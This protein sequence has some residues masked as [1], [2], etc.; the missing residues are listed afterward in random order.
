MKIRTSIFLL[1]LS[2]SLGLFFTQTIFGEGGSKNTAKTTKAEPQDTT[3]K[4]IVAI[5]NGQKVTRQELY[6]LLVDTY[7]DDAL[8]V[9]I[10][11]TLIY[12]A[13]A[14]EGISA[15]SSELNQKLKILIN[16]EIDGL[17]RTYRIKDKAD[18][19]KEL[20]KIDSS[21]AQLEEKLSKK[22]RKQAE[23]EVLAEKVMTKTVTVTEEELKK[24]YDLEY[25]EKIEA[26]QIVYNIRSD[27]E[28]ALKKIKSG[29]D[30]ATMAKNDSIDR[31]SAAKGG[32]MQPFSPKDGI[33]TQVAN[34]KVGEISDIIKTDYGYHIIQ[35]T[36]KKP[37]SNKDFKAVRSELEKTV[38]NQ[39]YK[40]RLGPWLI[41]LIENASIT[42]NL[43]ND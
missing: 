5:V 12:Q 10:R 42:K 38:R 24:V 22:M 7:G 37:A 27:A 30:F 1:I 17:M 43:P 23:V 34:L 6:E 28:D 11:R 15:T 39:R 40:E 33:G 9:L 16:G 19:E 21:I 25:G 36:G 14:K 31:V 13:A 18:L 3:D 35:I 8:D 32:K 20:I 2:L 26:S 4:N 29:A 41:S